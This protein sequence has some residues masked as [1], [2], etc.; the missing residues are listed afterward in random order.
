MVQI[1][2]RFSRKLHMAFA[3]MLLVTLSLAWYF[4]DSVKW[5]QYDIQRISKANEAL[6]AYQELSNLTLQEL[7]ALS[8]AVDLGQAS[9]APDAQR[10]AARLRGAISRV[11]QGV[12]AEMAFIG[13]TNGIQDLEILVDIER[14]T[15]EIISAGGVIRGALEEGRT[16]DASAELS[17]L[18]SSGAVGQFNTLVESA[19]QKKEQEALGAEHEAIS[20]AEYIT[21][22]LPLFMTILALFTVLLIS[23]FSRNLTRSVSALQEGATAFADGDLDYRI[24]KLRES[25]FVRLGEAFNTM[26]RELTNHRAE[27]HEANIS[28]ETTILERTSALQETNRKLEAM[29]S[30][31]RRLLADIS[32]EL[33]TPLTVIL[34][35]ADIAIRGEGET[36]SKHREVFQRI[37]DQ[38]DHT[39]RLVDDLL[40][41]ARADSGEPRLKLRSVAISGVLQAVCADF[42]ARAEK[43]K[44]TIENPEPDPKAVVLGDPGRLR[45]VFNIL[46]DNALRYSN[47]GGKV[48]IG[49]SRQGD[50]IR[51]TFR[52]HGIGLTE[53]EA[54]QAFQRFYRGSKA[55]KHARGTGLG[56][57]VAKAIVEAHK[58]RISLSGKLGEGATATVEIPAKGRLRAVA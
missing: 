21:Y 52:D 7:N 44:V 32:H 28:L 4:M 31:R 34:G 48:E 26:A 25:E 24:P 27:L 3:S 58:G 57:P 56:L 10:S 13:N 9:G 36:G 29:D 41:I 12:A 35:E 53:E 1:R 5:Y 22:M 33:R 8:E 47:P 15:E 54:E 20:L 6:A 51:V 19:L 37:R 50:D 43:E 42:G 49:L 30:N 38:A 14:L 23:F 40:F 18:R 55:E 16:G 39:T 11:R 17:A 2:T 46:L 45:Q